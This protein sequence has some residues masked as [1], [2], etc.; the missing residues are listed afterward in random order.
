MRGIF[1]K[2]IG[3]KKEGCII[4]TSLS[5]LRTFYTYSATADSQVTRCVQSPGFVVWGDEGASA[6]F[7][8]EPGSQ[9]IDSV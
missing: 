1:K 3:G 8:I 9:L 6:W 5:F 2:I 4:K 7:F